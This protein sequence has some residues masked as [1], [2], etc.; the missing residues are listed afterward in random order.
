MKVMPE[1]RPRP[2]L[3]ES[4]VEPPDQAVSENLWLYRLPAGRRR[5]LRLLI[6]IAVLAVLACGAAYWLVSRDLIHEEGASIRRLIPV[7]THRLSDGSHDSPPEPVVVQLNEQVI[8][9]TTIALGH[10]RLAVINGRRVAEGDTVTIRGSRRSVAVTLQVVEIADRKVKLT[11][12]E[13]IIIA[14]LTM[15][16]PTPRPAEAR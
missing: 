6:R 1:L 13:Q 15:A 14:H 8:Q 2:R 3:L 10:P 9:V 12:G 11:D 5:I 7:G 4:A 16:K